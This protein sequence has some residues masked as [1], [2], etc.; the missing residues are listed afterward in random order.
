M[1]SSYYAAQLE[2]AADRIADVSRSDL[3]ILLRRAAIRIRNANGLPLD[4]EVEDALKTISEELGHGRNEML[5][6]IVREWLEQNAYLP[7]HILDEDGDVGGN[8]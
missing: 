4:P 7:V 6:I 5:R 3:Q 8:G 1:T 2:D